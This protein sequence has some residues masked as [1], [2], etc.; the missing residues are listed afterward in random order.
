VTPREAISPQTA[1]CTSL[2]A[3]NAD[4]IIIL[5]CRTLH[6]SRAAICSPMVMVFDH[7]RVAIDLID[8]A[9]NAGVRNSRLMLARNWDLSRELAALL[10]DPMNRRAFFNTDCVA[11]SEVGQL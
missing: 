10:Y 8:R 1:A 7:Q 11:K 5:T 6:F 3:R 9:A 2:G 4:L